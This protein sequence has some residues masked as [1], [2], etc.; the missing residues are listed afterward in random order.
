MV[1]DDT[2]LLPDRLSAFHCAAAQIAREG[3]DAWVILCLGR[4]RCPANEQVPCAACERTYI[5][6]ERAA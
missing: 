2:T 4:A 3:G 6:P 5:F 1:A